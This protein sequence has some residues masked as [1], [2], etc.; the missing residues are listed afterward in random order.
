VKEIEAKG[1]VATR[2]APVGSG[3]GRTTHV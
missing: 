3:R 1:L 2:V